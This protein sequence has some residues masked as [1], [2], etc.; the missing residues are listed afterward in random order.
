MAD[1]NVIEYSASGMESNESGYWI[2]DDTND[3]KQMYNII[4]DSNNTE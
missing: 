2:L 3:S 4:L 1:D